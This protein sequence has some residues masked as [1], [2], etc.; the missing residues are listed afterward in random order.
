MLTRMRKSLTAVF[1]ILCA[2][3]TP[4]QANEPSPVQVEIISETPTVTPNTPFLV[5]VHLKIDEGWHTYWKSPGDIGMPISIEWDL[6]K[7]FEVSEI[8][9]P[10]PKKTVHD[11][12]I[13]YTHEN[14]VYLMVQITPPKHIS[15]NVPI[16]AQVRS[17]VCSDDMCLPSE[18]EAQLELATSQMPSTEVNPLFEAVKKQLPNQ[19]LQPQVDLSDSLVCIHLPNKEPLT[20][21]FCPEAPDLI[22]PI[23]EVVISKHETESIVSLTPAKGGDGSVKGVLV[24][25]HHD[26]TEEA[27]EIDASIGAG[28]LDLDSNETT[29]SLFIWAVI[30]AFIGGILLNLMPCVLPVL[31]F[32]VL[33]FVKLAKEDRSVTFKHG[34]AF[35]AGVIASFWAL[36]AALLI[37]K[38][39]GQAVGWG[40]QLQNPLFVA[41]LTAIIF[42]FSLSLF[43]LFEIGT[44][45]TSLAGKAQNQPSEKL[46]SSFCSGILATALA[47][48]CTGPFLGTAVGLAATMPA[49]LSLM[50]FTSLGLGMALPY[51]LL[52]AF[53]SCLRFIPKPGNWMV[54]FKECTGFFMMGTVLWLL[55]VFSAQTGSLAT[56]MLIAG[57]FFIAVATWIFGKWATPVSKKAVRWTSYAFTALFALVGTATMITASSI[58]SHQSATAE[59]WEP[60]SVERIEELRKEGTPVFVD[61]TAKWCLTCQANHLVLSTSQVD[62]SFVKEGVVKMKADWTTRDAAITEALTK[63]GRNSVPLYVYYPADLSEEPIILPQLLTPET[64]IDTIGSSKKLITKK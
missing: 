15:K 48:P 32:K 24:L 4:V 16:R 27:I 35:A 17:L 34:L 45:L 10:Y 13:T 61:F 50:I 57:L 8:Q 29:G 58:E 56:I 19:E 49:I 52:G 12:M 11:D 1:L 51:L 5:A 42:I 64:V 33:S 20:A 6:P 47:T 28:T 39:S 18:H 62:A 9:W 7:R 59:G 53:P 54:T 38:A 25:T 44:S 60:F 23:A 22:D 40:F 63:F 43:G 2:F 21:Y 41:A 55:W 36:A 3:C 46:S 26:G 14:D 31:S 37:L 30:F